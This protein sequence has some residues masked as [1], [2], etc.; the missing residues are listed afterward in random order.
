[1]ADFTT[2]NVIEL[3]K[4]HAA[5]ES[6]LDLECPEAQRELA[7]CDS[8]LLA[9][10][11]ALYVVLKNAEQEIEHW[12]EEAKLV[13]QARRSAESTVGRVKGLLNY[14][15]TA[16]PRVG[17]KLIGRN[18]KFTL[19]KQKN[20]K[21]E[22]TTPIEEWDAFEK[23]DFA[24]EEC[25]TTTTV[26]QSVVGDTV[27]R[28]SAT[29][30]RLIPNLDAIRHAYR[31]APESLPRGVRVTQSYAIRTGRVAGKNPTHSESFLREVD[32]TLIE[33]GSGD[34]PEDS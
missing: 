28:T 34:Q 5:L 19:V 13:A 22:L 25:I 10:I 9:K 11:D 7:A 21:V 6:S 4:S 33:E 16:A 31:T 18:Y 30:T 23:L 15:K 8:A 29:K 32:P 20:E 3:Y 1:M 14:V 2:L 26:L 12:K 24:L 17:N 27:S